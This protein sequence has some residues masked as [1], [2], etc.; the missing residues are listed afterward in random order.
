LKIGNAGEKIRKNIKEGVVKRF[1]YWY[2]IDNEDRSVVD[3]IDEGR[4]FVE[5][6][7]KCSERSWESSGVYSGFEETRTSIEG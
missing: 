7:R 3:V 6:A 5:V 4:G 2:I 1:W